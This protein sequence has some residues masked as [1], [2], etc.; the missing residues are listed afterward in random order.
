MKINNKK[1]TS[2]IFIS[3]IILVLVS[4]VLVMH[5]FL[6]QNSS[7][8]K[9]N[10]TLNGIRQLI[11]E[12][13]D[14]I[15]ENKNNT[16][17]AFISVDDTD[18]CGIIEV[19]SVKAELPIFGYWDKNKLPDY[20]CRFSG[21]IYN[22]D[23]IIGTSDRKGIFDFSDKLNIDDNIL[24]TDV[25]GNRYTYFISDIKSSK[26]VSNDY[27]KELNFDL[28]IFIKNELSFDYTVIICEF[29]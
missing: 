6:V 11:P 18:F 15:L 1:L 14:S 28:L 29:K 25:T 16:D 20:P 24:V 21:S 17:T 5:Y 8:N 23:L 13:N 2:L 27:F 22:S 7:Q 4:I 19:P 12:I 26:K 3:G 9:R 10:D